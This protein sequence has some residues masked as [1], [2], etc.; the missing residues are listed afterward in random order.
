MTKHRSYMDKG[1]QN[2]RVSNIRPSDCVTK[3][4]T[5]IK[6]TM[7]SILLIPEWTTFVFYKKYVVDCL[8]H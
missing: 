6:P 4:S 5:R 8:S 1:L 3:S 2:R 7:N